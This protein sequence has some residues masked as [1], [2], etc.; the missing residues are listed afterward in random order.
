MYTID[1]ASKSQEKAKKLCYWVIL[2]QKDWLN[3]FLSDYKALIYLI[4]R[5][6]CNY[7]AQ[8][9]INRFHWF[10]TLVPQNTTIEILSS[11]GKESY[12]WF[13]ILVGYIFQ[14]ECMDK[15]IKSNPQITPKCEIAL[16]SKQANQISICK[17]RK[18]PVICQN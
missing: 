14:F 16:R 7:C 10:Y 4:S 11:N 6:L 13:I 12:F 15:F 3:W 18:R 17:D 2:C 9:N 1:T 8:R 5:I